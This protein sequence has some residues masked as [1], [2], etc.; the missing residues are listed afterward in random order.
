MK[1]GSFVPLRGVSEYWR[2]QTASQGL[3][4]VYI[5]VYVL[6][7]IL[8]GVRS[9]AIL[10]VRL[11]ATGAW[12]RGLR[13][14]AKGIERICA[15]RIGLFRRCSTSSEPF[16]ETKSAEAS[17]HA[18]GQKRPRA[19]LV[20][21]RAMAID[22]LN[23]VRR[24]V[25][26]MKTK[27]GMVPGLAVIMVG[28][29]RDSAKYVS[30]KQVVAESVGFL[31]FSSIL[32]VTATHED[33]LKCIQQYNQDP[34][35][36]GILLQLPVP[37]HLDPRGLLGAIKVEKDV[38][39]FNPTNTGRLT[40]WR[41]TVIA[42]C[43]PR[44]VMEMLQ[45]LGVEVKGKHAV[46]LGESSVVGLPMCLMLN[47]A[48]ATVSM[49][50]KDTPDPAGYCRHADILVAATGVPELVRAGWVKPGA[51]VVDVGTNFV[52]DET[53][54]EGFR[55]V[56]DVH[57]GVRQRASIVSPVPGGV[58]PMTVAMLMRNCVDMAFLHCR[59]GDIASAM[60]VDHAA[61]NARRM[62][63]SIVDLGLRPRAGPGSGAMG[64]GLGR[65]EGLEG[66]GEEAEHGG[67]EDTRVSDLLERA[68]EGITDAELLTIINDTERNA[69]GLLSFLELGSS[70]DR[71]LG[72]G[73][74]GV[75][76][77]GNGDGGGQAQGQG[78]GQGPGSPHNHEGCS[79]PGKGGSSGGVAGGRSGQGYLASGEEMSMRELDEWHLEAERA[80]TARG[81]RVLPRSS[82]GTL[83]KDFLETEEGHEWW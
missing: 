10:T 2:I 23:E 40:A 41:R 70:H 53:R 76:G 4:F 16:H 42:P 5:Y 71:S 45:R 44:G 9:S 67:G 34:R 6:S 72:A 55:V 14:I 80:A 62:H 51:V 68:G 58:G 27:N 52:R 28:E 59:W 69:F 29:R 15:R 21:G 56:G 20:N 81:E 11:M 77:G 73:E 8:G 22:I 50:H 7:K 54:P 47:E 33:V 57:P 3:N 1:Q 24:E 74:V 32:P 63:S 82:E 13:P 18:A 65:K 25:D 78:Q 17:T 64:K 43:T 66:V 39:C 31:S 38:E 75:E 35:C 61:E 26:L 30:M 48:R 60:H 37:P 12:T 49:L 83:L 46:V 36:H 79:S 19:K